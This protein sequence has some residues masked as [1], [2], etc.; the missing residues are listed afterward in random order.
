MAVGA[1]STAPVN[2]SSRA[3][4]VDCGIETWF[5]A[6]R[7]K[8]QQQWKLPSIIRSHG[9]AMGNFFGAGNIVGDLVKPVM[10]QQKGGTQPPVTNTPAPT[11]ANAT[12]AAAAERTIM[13]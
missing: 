4:E 13:H 2:G 3:A 8:Q 5:T 9:S 6:N 12:A 1:G 10:K 7:Q 11:R